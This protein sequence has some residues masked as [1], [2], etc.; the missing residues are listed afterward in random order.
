MI[1]L[2]YTGPTSEGGLLKEGVCVDVP[3]D[4]PI[5]SKGCVT[6]D[7]RGEIIIALHRQKNI[8]VYDYNMLDNFKTTY[9]I[10]LKGFRWLKHW[11]K[12]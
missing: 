4:W 5:N 1:T 7:A 3:T 2:R 11:E 6:Q 8:S 9:S 12:V 10:S